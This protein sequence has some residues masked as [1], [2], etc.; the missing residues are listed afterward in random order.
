MRQT[1][2]RPKIGLPFGGGARGIAHSGVL[3]VIEETKIPFYAVAVD[4][5]SGKQLVL[6][7]RSIVKAVMASCA[8]PGFM[9]DWKKEVNNF[10]QRQRDQCAN[11]SEEEF[12]TVLITA[13]YPFFRKHNLPQLIP[14]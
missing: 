11:R 8:I 5:I 14:S 7:H 10:F 13:F 2:N 3:K 4:L 1:R 12:L 6:S 9:P